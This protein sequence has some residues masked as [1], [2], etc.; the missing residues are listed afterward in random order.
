MKDWTMFRSSSHLTLKIFRVIF[1]YEVRGGAVGWGTEL[2]DRS[3]RFRFPKM[4]LEFFIHINIPTA[5]WP[6]LD[7]ATNKTEYHEYFLGVKTAGA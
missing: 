1:Y 2:Q 7:Q 3:L 6:S 5:L 4:S